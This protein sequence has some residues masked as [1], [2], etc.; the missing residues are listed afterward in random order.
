MLGE[1]GTRKDAG[2]LVPLLGSEYPLVRSWARASV[3]RLI[4]RA[5]PVDLDGEAEGIRRD[6]AAFVAKAVE[7][8]R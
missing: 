3:E 8:R 2:L 1:R 7:E 5:L 6:A 4:G